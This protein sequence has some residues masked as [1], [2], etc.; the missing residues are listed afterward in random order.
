MTDAPFLGGICL[1]AS[2]RLTLYADIFAALIKGYYCLGREWI[3]LNNRF[4]DARMK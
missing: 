3:E 2:A 4:S 1:Q